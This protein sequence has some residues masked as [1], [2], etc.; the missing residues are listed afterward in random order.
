MIWVDCIL[1]AQSVPANKGNWKRMTLFY[2]T[3]LM[4]FNIALIMSILQLH[5]LGYIFYD[6]K[7]RIF[8]G[9]KLNNALSFFTLYLAL[10]LIINYIFVYRNNRYQKL[11]KKY[12]YYNGKLFLTYLIISML[13]V[14]IY[15]VFFTPTLDH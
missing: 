9:E 15:G 6:I 1:K 8:P 11:L 4:G 10:P 3:L 14:L 13:S 7:F 2:M 12:K 5:I